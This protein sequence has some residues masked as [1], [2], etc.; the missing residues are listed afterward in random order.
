M[1]KG[2]IDSELESCH[3]SADA[4]DR[5]AELREARDLIDYMIDQAVKEC[6]WNGATG[7]TFH[8]DSQPV[9]VMQGQEWHGPISW[10]RIADQLGVSRQTAWQRFR[11]MED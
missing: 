7:E 1:S 6:R 11:H 9:T 8:D 4:L 5:L 2:Q 10:Q 3:W